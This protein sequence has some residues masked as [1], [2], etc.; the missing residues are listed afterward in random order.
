MGPQA[1]S[2]L[3]P[4]LAATAWSSVRSLDRK[5]CQGDT[6]AVLDVEVI[7][8]PATASVALEPVRSRAAGRARPA[9]VGRVPRA[10]ASASPA[11]RSTTT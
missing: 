11:R 7:A 9:R 8:D 2:V 3:R 10:R 4:A 6:G 1:L 5:S